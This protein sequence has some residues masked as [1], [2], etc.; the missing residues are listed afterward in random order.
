MEFVTTLEMAIIDRN[1]EYLGIPRRVLME[2]AGRGVAELVFKRFGKVKATVVT[3]LGDNGGDGLV[4]ARY[5]HEW[6]C[7][8]K[9]ILLGRARDFRSELARENYNIIKLLGIETFEA[10]SPFEL[11]EVYDL[12]VSWCDVL[13]DAIV[14]TGL[15]GAL[16]EPQY[17]AIRMI[18]LSRAYRVAVDVPSG[19]DPDTGKV[20]DVAVRANLTV[21]M[22]KPKPGLLKEEARPYVGELVVIDIGIPREAEHMVGPGDLLVLQWKRRRESK[23]GDHGRVI[24]VGGSKEFSGAPALAAL[25]CFRTGVDL[26]T[27]VAPEAAAHDIRSISPDLI[28]TPVEGCYFNMP[29]VEQ[30]CKICEKAHVVLIGPGIGTREETIKFVVELLKTLSDKSVK[31]VIDADAIKAIAQEKAYQLLKEN[32]VITAH[33]GEFKLLFGDVPKQQNIWR[34][35]EEVCTLVKNYS[36]GATV[37]LKGNIDIITNGIKYKLNFTGNPAMT[38]G[39]TGDVLAGTVAGLLT[40]TSDIFEAACIATFVVGLAGDLAALEKG[41][42]ILP[43]DV[44]ENM[45][46]VFTKLLEERQEIESVAHVTSLTLL[47]RLGLVK[48]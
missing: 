45:P 14:G 16:R 44:I 35:A 27:I 34:R 28:V 26:V 2:N 31:I 18:N 15:R 10:A 47:R 8:V 13:I 33:A 36:R 21:T 32:I 29:H 41:Y 38:V 24:I 30:V 43:T 46:M 12:I 40:K 4:A 5:L 39:G 19:L 22:H 11:Q 6:G 42:H 20:C 1:C 3:G 23:K 37:V 7:D 48:T 25:A 9:V 17:T